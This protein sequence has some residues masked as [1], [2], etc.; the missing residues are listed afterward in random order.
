MKRR[1]GLLTLMI[2]AAFLAFLTVK[3]DIFRKPQ[4]ESRINI[5]QNLSEDMD[6]AGGPEREVRG[7]PKRDS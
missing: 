5:P 4:Q 6:L 7:F 3:E 1:Y 2:L